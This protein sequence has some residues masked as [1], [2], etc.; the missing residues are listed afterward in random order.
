MQNNVYIDSFKTL[1][2]NALPMAFGEVFAAMETKAIDGQE[3][4]RL[5]PSKRRKCM[6]V[7]KYLTLSKHA[8]TPF[9]VLYS[10]KLF[11]ALSAEEQK[12]I[13]D[14]AIA[15]RDEERKVNREMN[16]KALGVLKGE[17]HGGLRAQRAGACQD[18]RGNHARL[19]AQSRRDGPGYA[20]A[21]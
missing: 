6:S 16:A 14:C 5:S 8:Y 15:G 3:K 9:P 21:A 10:K 1:G 18:A 7:Q 20:V 2:A 17:G 4:I 11:D 19:R 13:I 12:I